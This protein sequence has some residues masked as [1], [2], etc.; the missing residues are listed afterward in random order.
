MKFSYPIIKKP[1]QFEWF[2]CYPNFY[3]EFYAGWK[4]LY[5]DMFK[6]DKLIQDY[7]ISKQF[8]PDFEWETKD[9]PIEY[10]DSFEWIDG[11]VK[12]IGKVYYRYASER[13][14]VEDVWNACYLD[15]P[16][17]NNKK[18]GFSV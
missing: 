16:K 10:F 2:T 4:F 7:I 3:S 9:L 17:I 1:F 12:I 5:V 18:A 8:L 11:E 15:F 13:I 14:S 6:W